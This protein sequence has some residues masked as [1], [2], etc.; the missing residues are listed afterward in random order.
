MD[1]RVF[2]DGACQGNGKP[3][4]RASY[5]YW[6]P[7]HK[8]HSF[9]ARIP[10]NQQQT[11]QRGELL[12][13]HECVKKAIQKFSASEISLKIYTDSTYSKDCLTKWLPGWIANDW[14]TS[15]GKDVCHKD[16]IDETAS[17]LTQFKSYT[18]S[19]VRAH[20]GGEDELSRNNHIVDRMAVAVLEPEKEMKVI[21]HD[22]SK[23]PIEGCPL[24]LMGPPIGEDA[25]VNWCRDNLDKLDSTALK[26]ALISA[27]K[28][29]VS[30]NGYDIEKQRFHRSST[31][32]LVSSNHL[33][34]ESGT[35]TKEE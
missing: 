23:A 2:T 1:V 34:A 4:A 27:F 25:L 24:L 28:K 29:T 15:T 10:D 11:N 14:K 33:I 9:A 26:S 35:I 3:G 5:A 30:K 12:A 17:L 31:Y 6:F 22:T 19:Y 8:E 18:I 20:T 7:D 32:R 16:I 13:I 21:V